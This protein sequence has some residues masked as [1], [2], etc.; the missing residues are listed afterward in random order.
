[1]AIKELLNPSQLVQK[2]RR[3]AVADQD[4][5]LAHDAEDASRKETIKQNSTRA[6]VWN[7]VSTFAMWG[8][9]SILGFG[10]SAVLGHLLGASGVTMGLV[11]GVGGTVAALAAIGIGTAYIAHK[12]SVEN[13]FNNMAHEAKQFGK[14]VA[15]ELQ[16]NGQ[17]QE[18]EQ[19]QQPEQRTPYQGMPS[20]R[21]PW[22]SNPNDIT[23]TLQRQS[24][25]HA[26]PDYRNLNPAHAEHQGSIPVSETLQQPVRQ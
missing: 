9:F 17:T 6:H 2:L 16:G 1:M 8:M 3:S 20:H 19:T 21:S 18:R 7:R 22:V 13:S 23:A 26:Q 4:D 10:T 25:Q 24:K 15:K 5:G 11:A 14:A 12:I